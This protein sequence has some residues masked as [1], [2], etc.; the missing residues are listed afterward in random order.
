VLRIG[1]AAS[2]P[3]DIEQDVYAQMKYDALAYFYHNR[4]G[5][6]IEMPYVGEEK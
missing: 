5:I 3:F 6:P 2:D 4:S 1:N